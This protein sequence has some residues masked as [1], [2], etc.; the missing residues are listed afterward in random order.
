MEALVDIGSIE[1]KER[2]RRLAADVA[3]KLTQV[4]NAYAETRFPEKKS[5]SGF[6]RKSDM[7]SKMNCN[8]CHEK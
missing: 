7:I 4:L 3:R 6:A 8:L 5:L 1:R 2:C